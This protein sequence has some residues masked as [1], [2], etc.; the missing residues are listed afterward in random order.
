MKL[1]LCLAFAAMF[2]MT[3]MLAGCSQPL[4]PKAMAKQAQA[5]RANGL[6]PEEVHRGLSQ[7]PVAIACHLPRPVKT[8]D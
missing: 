7:A 3:A 8:C 4:T 5:C 2:G 1:K 6:V